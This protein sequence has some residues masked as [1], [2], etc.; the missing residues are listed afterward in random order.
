[1]KQLKLFGKQVKWE[2]KMFWRNPPA[3]VFTFVFPLIFLVIFSAINSGDLVT[4]EGA[5][6]VKVKFTQYYVPSIVLFGIIS[7]CYTALA[8]T[9]C[10]RRVQGIL[11][12]KRGTPLTA[13]V[14]MGGVVGNSLIVAA[15]LTSVTLLAGIVFYGFDF[16]DV[17]TRLPKFV[18]ILAVASF[19]FSALGI[20]VSTFVPNEDAAPA[21]INVVLFPLIFIS[22]TFGPIASTSVLTKVAKVFPVWHGIHAVTTV[23]HPLTAGAIDWTDTAI[24]FVWGVGACVLAARRFRWDPDA[25]VRTER[26]RTRRSRRGG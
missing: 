25:T 5:E 22:G 9:L 3:A 24:M 17:A 7:A 11:K 18:F 2:Q 8:F 19:C 14:Y 20:L 13:T 26:S 15:L 16:P 21:I 6:G 10:L 12:R 4:V 1:V 23:T